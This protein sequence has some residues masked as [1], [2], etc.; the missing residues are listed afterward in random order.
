MEVPDNKTKKERSPAQQEATRKMLQGLAERRR[1]SW[2]AKKTDMIS[3]YGDKIKEIVESE[4]EPVVPTEPVHPKTKHV[5]IKPAQH[6]PTINIE[7]IKNQIRDELLKEQKSTQLKKKPTK[8]RVVLE[9][10]SESE[11]EVLIVRKPKPKKA[12]GCPSYMMAPEPS[13]QVQTP[14]QVLEDLFF[15]RR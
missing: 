6:K 9:E 4:E 2:E 14:Y 3:K 15:R 12:P 10:S 13:Q 5:Q 1:E 7:E 11:E 8:K